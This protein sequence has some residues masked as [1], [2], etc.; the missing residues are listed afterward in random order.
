MTVGSLILHQLREMEF[1]IQDIYKTVVPKL[2]K[3]HSLQ[4]SLLKPRLEDPILHLTQQVWGGT[5]ES[6]PPT[7]CWDMRLLTCGKPQAM[8]P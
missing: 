1:G 4:D 7:G 8:V 6:A 2:G 3:I 5:Q